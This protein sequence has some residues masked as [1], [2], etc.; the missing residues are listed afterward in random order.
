[1]CGPGLS[2]KALNFTFF[3]SSDV[4]SGW[5]ASL[6]NVMKQYTEKSMKHWF[7]LYQMV[8]KYQQEQSEK[9]IEGNKIFM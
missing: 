5:S 9:K 8:E 3:F 1:M 4:F 6:D 7:S 2:Y